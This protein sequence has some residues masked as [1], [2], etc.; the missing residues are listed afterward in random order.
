MKV[1]EIPVSK[2]MVSGR[3]PEKKG[4]TLVVVAVAAA[5]LE[6]VLVP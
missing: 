6:V 2:L 4:S 5:V 3:V 1:F